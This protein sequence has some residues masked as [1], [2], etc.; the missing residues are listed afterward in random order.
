MT[1]IPASFK[2]YSIHFF[3]LLLIGWCS[4]S[5]AQTAVVSGKIRSAGTKETLIGATIIS[6][7]GA[8]TVSDASGNYRLELPAG[9]HLLTVRLI[10]YEPYSVTVILTAGEVRT[11]DVS[12]KETNLE[13]GTVVVSASKY[14]QRLEDVTVSMEV[15]KPY[16]VENTIATSAE[17]AIDQLPGVSVVDGQANIR[18]GS[19]WSY[20]AGSRVQVMIDDL[21]LLSADAGDAKWSFIPTENLEQAEVLK[22]A[23]SVLF[24]SSALNGTINFRT[25]YPREKPET[26]V[27]F[28][29]GFYDH[30]SHTLN[31]T[32]YDIDYWNS[33]H[34]WMG[35]LSFLHAQKFGNLDVVAG[36]NAFM[37]Q[38][39]RKDDWEQRAR[40][41]T[42]LRYRVPGID[43]LSFGINANYMSSEGVTYFLWKNCKESAYLPAENTASY[44]TTLRATVDPY[45]TYVTPEGNMHKLR[46]RY[47]IT[48][49]RNNTDQSSKAALN[50]L[51]YQYL[52]KFGQYITATG[53][54]M[55]AVNKVNSELFG[56]HT[57]LQLGAYV[58]ADVAYGKWNISAGGRAEKYSVDDRNEQWAP[59]TRIGVNYR[60][61]EGTFLRGSFGQGYRFPTVAELFVKTNV[62]N[63]SVYPDS[64]LK[65][66]TGQ[67]VEMGVKQGFKVRNWKGLADI[68]V[69]QNKYY[70][71]MEFTFA[72]WGNP[73]TDPLYGFGFSSINIGNTRIRGAE[74]TLTGEGNLSE[75]SVL[76]VLGGYTYLDPRLVS[77]DSTWLTKT[78]TNNVLGSAGND[79]LKYRFRHTVKLDVEFN[80]PKWL[81]GASL[82]YTSFMENIDYIFTTELFEIAFPGFGVGYYRDNHRR[83][84]AVVDFRSA[85]K[86]KHGIELSFVVRN[87][88]NNIYMQ[89]PA[90]MQAPRQFVT[91]IKVAF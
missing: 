35:G 33:I 1:D 9:K 55:T 74:L 42:N 66:E 75:K 56:N 73:L 14:E 36:A 72:Q 7:N 54:L 59:V 84:D 57:G 22:G 77:F 83:G 31:D 67:S 20:G 86:W 88:F 91:Q 10:S 43:G 47:F 19:G 81:V 40:F 15:L 3:L 87:L 69:F 80:R 30:A 89:R 61:T 16:L 70:D 63:L 46:T 51:E 76:R 82:R 26:K 79:F 17:Q 78:D 60:L 50:Y 37:D 32:T 45:A 64:V 38:G 71:M 28:F 24:G 5:S 62:G 34:P 44:Y 68:A 52:H 58:Q 18:G 11:L 41:N 4:S 53:G 8:G 85:Y 6:G 27:A 48:D 65:P 23:S 13:L 39:Y 90:D 49:N 12:L 25:R 2:H 21:P 29:Q